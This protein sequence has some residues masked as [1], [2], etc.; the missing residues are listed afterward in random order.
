MESV[1]TVRSIR[2]LTEEEYNY[3]LPNEVSS[4]SDQP[5]NN[6]QPGFVMQSVIGCYQEEGNKEDGE[7][8]EDSE[9]TT[10]T[11]HDTKTKTKDDVKTGTVQSD[12]RS[13]LFRDMESGESNQ[14]NHLSILTAHLNLGTSTL[15]ET[16]P[17]VQMIESSSGSEPSRSS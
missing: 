11:S 5:L 1:D 14:D 17:L 2:G 8:F 9:N 3:G 12:I 15:R 13:K 4:T 10:G 6:N 16:D 7:Y